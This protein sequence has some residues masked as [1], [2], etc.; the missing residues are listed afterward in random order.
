MHTLEICPGIAEDYEQVF[1][2][3]TFRR[4]KLYSGLS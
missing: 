1:K 2:Q 3:A 4:S